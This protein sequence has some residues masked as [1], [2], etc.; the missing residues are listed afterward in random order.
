VV[1]YEMLTGLPP[2]YSYNAAQM[3]ENVLRQRLP[4]PSYLSNAS[5]RILKQLLCV[6]PHERLGSKSG[7]NEIK[8]HVF[9]RKVDWEMVT[10]RELHPP[11][12]PCRSEKSI[13]CY[14]LVNSYSI[15][16]KCS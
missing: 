13:V 6:E 1:L 2:W 10:F 11:I 3:R 12:Q 5:K 9:F 7:S 14:Y 4:L 16:T 15:R 8:N